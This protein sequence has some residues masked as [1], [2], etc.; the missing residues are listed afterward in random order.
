MTCSPTWRQ[1]CSST[2]S[3][4]VAVAMVHGPK[5]VLVALSWTTFGR[6]VYATGNNP[7]A[8]YLSGVNVRLLTVSLYALSGLFASLTGLLL[9]AYGGKATLGMGDPY[10][11]QSIAAIVVGGIYILGGRGHYLGALA[12]AITLTALVI[13]LLYG[14]AEPE[15]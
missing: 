9:M 2:L 8:G 15:P 3:R 7:R 13:L 4:A 11:F 6:R 12:G 5:A 14:R 10:L 1:D